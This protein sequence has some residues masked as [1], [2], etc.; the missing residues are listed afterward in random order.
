MNSNSKDLLGCG[1]PHATAKVA[2]R[3]RRYRG[4]QVGRSAIAR[5]ILAGLQLYLRPVC[6]PG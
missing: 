5:D 2:R 1:E 4:T 6:Q 3:L